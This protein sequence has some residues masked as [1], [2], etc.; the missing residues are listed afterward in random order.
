[1]SAVYVAVVVVAQLTIPATDVRTS[2]FLCASA[3]F[4]LLADLGSLTLTGLAGLFGLQSL[5]G[6]TTRLATQTATGS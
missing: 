2:V 3:L 5:A 1:M 6:L 4:V